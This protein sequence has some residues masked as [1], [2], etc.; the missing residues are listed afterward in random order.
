M[1]QTYWRKRVASS[2]GKVSV[3]AGWRKGETDLL[4]EESGSSIGKVSVEA[5]RVRQT[6]WRKRMW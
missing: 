2:I 1:R 3:E 4:E 6:Y 5:G